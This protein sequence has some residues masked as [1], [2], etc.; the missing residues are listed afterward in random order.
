MAT[1]FTAALL[2][3]MLVVIQLYCMGLYGNTADNNA[4]TSQNSSYTEMDESLSKGAILA[5]DD[6]FVLSYDLS[7]SPALLNIEG[8]LN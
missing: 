4:V 8:S 5:N 6:G 2:A 1:N 7:S 3:I